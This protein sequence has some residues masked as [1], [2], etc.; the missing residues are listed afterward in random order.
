MRTI[1]NVNHRHAIILKILNLSNQVSAQSENQCML[2]TQRKSTFILSY[3]FGVCC[4]CPNLIY[5]YNKV[6]IT[7]EHCLQ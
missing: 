7:K 2:Y 4:C 3:V 1:S 6:C 5:F